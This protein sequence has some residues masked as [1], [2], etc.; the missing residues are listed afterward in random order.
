MDS[1]AAAVDRATAAAIRADANRVTAK[2]AAADGDGMTGLRPL[3]LLRPNVQLTVWPD[4]TKGSFRGS[5]S[6]DLIAKFWSRFGP[7]CLTG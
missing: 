5:F 4:G 1:S 3:A 2:V 7:N 6:T